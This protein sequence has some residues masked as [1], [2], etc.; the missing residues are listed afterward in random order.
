MIFE[1]LQQLAKKDMLDGMF[2]EAVEK[3]KQKVEA[4]KAKGTDPADVDMD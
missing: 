3:K 4:A 2:K 1:L